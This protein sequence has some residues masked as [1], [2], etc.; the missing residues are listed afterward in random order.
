M[1]K[2]HVRMYTGMRDRHLVTDQTPARRH[3][4]SDEAD[5]NALRMHADGHHTCFR[6]CQNRSRSLRFRSALQHRKRKRLGKNSKET[7]IFRSPRTQTRN[8]DKANRK[9]WSICLPAVSTATGYPRLQHQAARD[10]STRSLSQ[11]RGSSLPLS[12]SSSTRG[13]SRSCSRC[14]HLRTRSHDCCDENLDAYCCLYILAS[15]KMNRVLFITP[16]TQNF[17]RSFLPKT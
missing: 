4:R 7:L 15:P 1:K 8:K 3:V 17:T 14:R 13:C 2:L 6:Q 16:I 5:V 9:Q 12:P 11:S 10:D